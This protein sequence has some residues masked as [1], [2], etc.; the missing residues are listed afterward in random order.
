MNKVILMG[1]LTKDPE[2]RYT[3][4]NNVARCTFSIAVDRKFSR[5]GE[6]KQTDFFNIVAWRNQAE[7]CSKYFTKGMRVAVVGSLQNRNWDDNEGKKHTI[8]EVVAEEVHFADARKNDG[9]PAYGS[10]GS[11]GFMPASSGQG[12]EGF[13]PTDD[14]DELPF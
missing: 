4:T 12:D 10:P 5:P 2:L 14:D 9:G 8:T 11:A 3:T 6:E 1:R 7:F 13:F